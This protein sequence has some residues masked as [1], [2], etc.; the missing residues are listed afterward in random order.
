MEEKEVVES[1]ENYWFL[2]DDKP[3]EF[4]EGKIVFDEEGNLIK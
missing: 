3:K 1:I 4:L 2:R